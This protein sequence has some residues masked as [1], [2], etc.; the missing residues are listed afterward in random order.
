MYNVLYP[1][2]FKLWLGGKRMNS[3]S[4]TLVSDWDEYA[5]ANNA[6]A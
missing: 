1:V 5:V 4:L 3:R 6:T 2:D